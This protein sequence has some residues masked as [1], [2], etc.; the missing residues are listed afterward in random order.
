MKLPGLKNLRTFQL[1]ARH[2]SFKA[3]AEE[4][5]VTPSAV[6]HQIKTLEERLGLTLFDRGTQSLTLTR[7]GEA[8]FKK[9]DVIFARLEQTTEELISRFGRSMLHIQMPPFFSSELFLPKLKTFQEAYPELD[10]RIETSLE[11]DAPLP[12]NMDLSIALGD[13]PWHDCIAENLFQ[14][15]YVI[16]CSPDF[17]DKHSIRRVSD[18]D[19]KPLIVMDSRPDIWEQAAQHLHIGELKPQK[20]VHVDSM[21][22]VAKGAEKGLGLALLSWP[23]AAQWFKSD[24]LVR[25]FDLEIPSTESFVLLHR[26]EDQNRP[27]VQQL[28]EWIVREFRVSA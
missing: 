16:A 8:Y 4:L 13:G 18:L 23:A 20:L 3:A 25:L 11:K 14:Q 2:E 22:Q 9:L 6:S 1:A 12:S 5:F 21:P 15:R 7:A 10:L 24:N 26:Q 17:R 19:G 28:R 27:E